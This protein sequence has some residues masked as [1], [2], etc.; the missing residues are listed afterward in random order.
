[1]AHLGSM[2]LLKPVLLHDRL[3][4]P[5]VY[6]S[7]SDDTAQTLLKEVQ[8]QDCP[9][10]PLWSWLE[11]QV[12]TESEH[13][14]KPLV[15]AKCR[16]MVGLAPIGVRRFWFHLGVSVQ[17]WPLSA[18]VLSS[19]CQLIMYTAYVPK[20]SAGFIGWTGPALRK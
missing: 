15:T 13:W 9:T 1:M 18:L 12:N 10:L 4:A 14:S 3:T 5:R 17:G 20:S 7:I 6:E 19:S 8:G 11:V 2:V 16:E